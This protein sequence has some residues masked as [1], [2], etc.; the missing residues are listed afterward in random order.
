MKKENLDYDMF[1]NARVT[2][3]HKGVYVVKNENGEYLAKITGKRNFEAKSREDYP[4]VGDWVVIT[5]ID[6]DQAIIDKILPRRS[7]LKRKHSGKSEKDQVIATNI[8]IVFAV[9]AVDRDYNLNRLERYL[10]LAKDQNIKVAIILNK[11]DLISSEELALRVKEIKERFDNTD[12]ILTSTITKQGLNNLLNYIEK[13]KTYCFLGSSGVGKSSLINKLLK[14]NIIKTKEISQHGERGRHATTHRE[15]YF[16]ENGGIVIDNP[17]MRE[18]GLVDSSEGMK[19]VFEEIL[20]LAGKCKYSDCTHIHEPGCEVLKVVES[21]KLDK[22]KYLNYLKL[23]SENK[24]T[25]LGK[26]YKIKI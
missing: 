25:F 2:A 14:E 21:K 17:G 5:K 7:I 6:K 1:F 8:D 9:E 20:N 13:E 4:A 10:V 11:V 3:E 22:D 24:F 26:G 19:D 18:V 12:I 16:L 23:K 15:M